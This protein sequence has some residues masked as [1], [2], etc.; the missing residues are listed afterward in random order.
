VHRELHPSFRESALAL[1][2][3]D[4]MIVEP[5]SAVIVYSV[6]KKSDFGTS[7]TIGPVGGSAVS[8]VIDTIIHD[9]V[10]GAVTAVDFSRYD[11]DLA[12]P[13]AF[14]GSPI[15]DGGEFVGILVGKISPQE[16]SRI[17]TQD[18]DWESM[19]LGNTGEIFLI[20]SDGRGDA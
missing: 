20:G 1:G 2:F 6:A 8:S 18:G 12:A 4:V 10:K 9:P 19:R 17:T 3:A 13:V 15:F 7:L 5:Q 11:P 16:I 14:V